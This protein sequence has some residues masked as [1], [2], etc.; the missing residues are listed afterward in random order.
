MAKEDILTLVC[1]VLPVYCLMLHTFGSILLDYR[2]KL[3]R[4]G[5]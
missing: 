4:L 3:H 1:A 2:V 5:V